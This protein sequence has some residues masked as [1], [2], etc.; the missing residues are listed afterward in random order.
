MQCCALSEQASGVSSF[1]GSFQP[2]QYVCIQLLS[3]SFISPCLELPKQLVHK[4]RDSVEEAIHL[5]SAA[6]DRAE[7][8]VKGDEEG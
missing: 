3:A 5:E 7:L 4:Q 2:F 8:F 1:C 6:L